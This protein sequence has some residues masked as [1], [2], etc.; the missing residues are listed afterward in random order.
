MEIR[1]GRRK[2][3]I[4]RRLRKLLKT[5][6]FRA[7]GFLFSNGRNMESVLSGLFLVCVGSH[8]GC[9][10]GAGRAVIA[11]RVFACG[12]IFRQRAGA[13][14]ERMYVGYLAVTG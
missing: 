14:M 10:Y 7:A 2:A 8:A 9:G 6:V 12:V 11:C 1:G 5:R 13:V 4:Y 3:V